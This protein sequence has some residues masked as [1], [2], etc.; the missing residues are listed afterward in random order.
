MT[1]TD[2][3]F[4]TEDEESALIKEV[5][6]MFVAA[7]MESRQIPLIPDEFAKLLFQ[8]N[9][10]AFGG[11]LENAERW[12][13]ERIERAEQERE[14]DQARQMRRFLVDFPTTTKH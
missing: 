10:D 8:I 6:E 5:S 4:P 11:R 1:E 7:G 2:Y 12:L 3:R 13:L 9:P 14:E